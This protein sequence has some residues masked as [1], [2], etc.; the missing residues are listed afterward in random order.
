M[1]SLNTSDENSQNTRVEYRTGR[2][3]FYLLG[4]PLYYSTK[5]LIARKEIV[6][7]IS[8]IISTNVCVL[9]FTLVKI[10]PSRHCSSCNRNDMLVT[11]V[12]GGLEKSRT[13][14]FEVI[15]NLCFRVGVVRGTFGV[16]GGKLKDKILKL[17]RSMEYTHLSMS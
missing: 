15:G 14:C 3:G 13:F 17:T 4:L 12:G 16:V 9:F 5:E 7:K 8:D 2:R 11:V 10:H 6:I 1:V